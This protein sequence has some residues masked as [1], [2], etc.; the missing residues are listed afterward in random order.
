MAPPEAYNEA[1]RAAE[2]KRISMQKKWRQSSFFCGILEPLIEKFHLSGLSVSIV[3]GTRQLIKYRIGL[4]MDVI[5]RNASL[6]GH[7]LLSNGLFVLLDAGRD[8]RTI[9]NPLVHGPPFIKFYAGMPLVSKSTNCAIGVLAVFDHYPRTTV[10]A[11]FQETLELVSQE[12]MAFLDSSPPVLSPRIES[13]DNTIASPVSVGTQSN[14]SR[15]VTTVEN[16]GIPGLLPRTYDVKCDMSTVKRLNC[17]PVVMQSYQISREL[18]SCL[19]AKGA[20]EKACKILASSLALDICYVVEVRA[21][22]TYKSARDWTPVPSGT[23]LKRLSGLENALGPEV[24]RSIHVRLLGGCGVDKDEQFDNEVHFLALSSKYGVQYDAPDE[25]MSHRSGIF[26]P[27]QQEYEI[28][29]SDNAIDHEHMPDGEQDGQMT[30][31]SS[32]P[33]GNIFRRFA[34]MN[35]HDD[36]ALIKVRHGGYVMAGLGVLHHSFSP[37][38]VEYMKTCVKGLDNILA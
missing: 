12:I 9:Y 13:A 11:Q 5:S 32:S 37:G 7:A 34:N 14:V 15:Q 10:S 17:N 23:K 22:L 21:T 28:C 25:K 27:F 4:D 19:N 29:Y 24:R 30:K 20:I 18:L 1:K 8:W 36:T 38:D 31:A 6:D 3:D 33:G 2:A 16:E 35:I 26:M